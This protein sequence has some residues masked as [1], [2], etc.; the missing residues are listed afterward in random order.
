MSP[1][2]SSRCPLSNGSFV[3][4]EW[5]AI[6][7]V[8][9]GSQAGD[10]PAPTTAQE[11]NTSESPFANAPTQPENPTPTPTPTPT[12]PTVATSPTAPTAATAIPLP[13]GGSI[14]IVP[15]GIKNPVGV[16]PPVQ[17]SSG[18]E[19]S[20]LALRVNADYA[21]PPPGVTMNGSL[22]LGT[23]TKPN[24]VMAI[25][26][27]DLN[28][29]SRKAGGQNVFDTS[30]KTLLIDQPM[31]GTGPWFSGLRSTWHRQQLSDMRQAGIDVALIHAIDG[32][33]RLP[34]EVDALVAA[35]KDLKANGADYPLIGVDA[36]GNAPGHIRLILDRIPG[37]FRAKWLN[38]DGKLGALVYNAAT[39]PDKLADD[40]P[41]AVVKS[42]E[43]SLVNGGGADWQGAM[44]GRKDGL[45]YSQSW[46]AAA[47]APS[48]VLDSWNDY[49]RG[50]ELGESRQYGYKYVDQTRIHTIDYNGGHQW[51]AKYLSYSVPQTFKTKTIYTVR[52]RI[53]NAGSLP[54]RAGEGYAL[55]ARWYHDGRLFDDSAPRIPLTHD[56]MPG[57]STDV[58]L[59][60]VAMNGYGDDLD[61][62]NYILVFDM[63][64]GA[65]KWFSYAADK[66]LQIPVTVLAKDEPMDKQLATFVSSTTP[67]AIDAGDTATSSVTIRNDGTAPLGSV[68]LGYKIISDT[69]SE[70]VATGEAVAVAEMQSGDVTTTT[71]KIPTQSAATGVY[72][73]HWYLENAAGPVDGTYDEGIEIDPAGVHPAFVLSDIPRQASAGKD[74][75]SRIAIR[76]LGSG[77]WSKGQ[78]KVGYHWYYLDGTE[79]A[80]DGG[81]TTPINI[82]V[83]SK[84]AEPDLTVKAHAPSVPGRYILAFDGQTSDGTWTST[85]AGLTP[86]EM[87]PVI[88]TVTG[89]TSVVPV[90]L[91]R[92]AS[93]AD[94][95][96]ASNGGQLP[97]GM[98]PPDGAGEVDVNPLLLG[99]PGAPLYPSGYYAHAIGTGWDSNHAVPFLYAGDPSHAGIACSGQRVDL[100]PGP[101]REI[102]IL[103]ASTSTDAVTASFGAADGSKVAATDLSIAS[104]KTAPPLPAW[105]SPYSITSAGDVDPT[106]CYL[107]DYAI[108]V[109]GNVDGLVLPNA[110]VKVL[111]VTLVR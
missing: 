72:R 40:T 98:L 38:D 5:A 64:E 12:P 24:L 65:D 3:S 76:N 74:F 1:E 62:G 42:T 92:Y 60:V 88:V 82:P 47:A 53:E 68:K 52:V 10:A 37:E 106:P 66:P 91:T 17:A 69:G 73:L 67:V 41:V 6:S 51:H 32:D 15:G 80:W 49:A 75:S 97:E 104:W 59:G 101:C 18:A 58:N 77:A 46:T 33:K 20:P 19:H 8:A 7:R 54:W 48:V 83:A 84:Q 100:P 36:T 107:G 86:F 35:L 90:D 23:P 50:T 109:G 28:G 25:Y 13:G 99:K 56:I 44:T 94:P 95:P 55:C 16:R 34:Y 85:R 4:G 2:A 43:A 29:D 22:N 70:V 111:A 89:K 11:P 14:R 79:A 30:G 61:P 96:F 108:K 39:S 45:T 81:S 63:V 31:E 93:T 26:R 78:I 105:S 110:G 21:P 102:H 27:V 87:L 71:V 103:A 9:V 57:Q